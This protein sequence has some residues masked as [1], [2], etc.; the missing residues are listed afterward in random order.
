M[1]L[2]LNENAYRYELENVVRL[3][4]WDVDIREGAPDGTCPEFVYAEIRHMEEFSH[5]KVTVK[6]S[7][8]CTERQTEVPGCDVRE[9]EM[10]FAFLVFEL[11]SEAT[12]KRPP[13]GIMT[14]VRPAKNFASY[15]ENG[16]TEEAAENYVKERFLLTDEKAR[17]CRVT[18]MRGLELRKKIRPRGYSLYVSIPFCP[19]RCSYCSFVSKSIGRE[20]ALIPEYVDCLCRELRHT[21][22]IV[23]ENG[24]V[25]QTIYIGGGTPTVLEERELAKLTACINE[26]FGQP[27]DGEYCVEAGRPDTI[28]A[29]KLKVLRES[30]VTRI[31]I[32]PQTSNDEVLRKIGR[33]HTASDIERCYDI[34]REEGFG[35]INADF[36]AG[37]EGDTLESFRKSIAWAVER[38]QAE[39]I[40]VHA[41]TLKRA[42]FMRETESSLENGDAAGMVD[43]AQNYLMECGY[44]PYYMYR[45]KGT[46]G[47]LENT[48]YARKGFECLYNLFIMDEVQSIIA[49]GAGAV[50]KLLDPENGK[51]SRIFDL[52]YPQEYMARLDEM[53]ERKNGIEDVFLH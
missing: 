19:T 2:F 24:L 11:L 21:A 25:L 50:T 36:I 53:M 3:F 52:K 33:R 41:L 38:L 30:G 12:G 22:G 5:L 42:S 47:G 10:Q 20:R 46:V 6:T 49:C 8:N 17:L 9:N 7:G 48:G 34:A 40:T 1:T 26:S 43:F 14:G 29:G 28:A 32:N 35:N 44:D 18:A 45:Q 4:F 31:S 27:L 23:K 13:F 37:L 51:I 15:V 39:S 16:M